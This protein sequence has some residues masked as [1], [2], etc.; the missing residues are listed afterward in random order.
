MQLLL[1][2]NLWAHA[3]SD[4]RFKWFERRRSVLVHSTYQPIMIRRCVVYSLRRNYDP[5]VSFLVQGIEMGYV[6]I[7]RGLFRFSRSGFID[8]VGWAVA[9]CCKALFVSFILLFWGPLVLW[10]MCHREN[11]NRGESQRAFSSISMDSFPCRIKP[12][13]SSINDTIYL[14]NFRVSVDGDW[15]CLKELHDLQSCEFPSR[16]AFLREE[17]GLLPF[18]L[19]NTFLNRIEA[20]RSKRSTSA[21]PF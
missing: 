2:S 15:L 4:V 3:C 18:F 6:T 20:F 12:E 11:S 7:M 8:R 13:T 9:G 16:P 17:Y 10:W 5:L 21:D 1:K 14:C 19:Q